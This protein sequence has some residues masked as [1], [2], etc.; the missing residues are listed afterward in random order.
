[1]YT[2]NSEMKASVVERFNR[3]LK[4]KMWR[5]FT[6]KQSL[7][8]IDVLQDLVNSYNSSYHRSIKNS[9][10]KIKKSNEKE[11]YKILF[12]SKTLPLVKFLY[13]KGD[14]VRISKEKGVF[15]KGYTPNF[16]REIF[17]I[18]KVIPR[19]PVVYKL[20][21]LMDEKIE[22]VFYEQQ[23][24]K[25]LKDDDIYYISDLVKTRKKKGKTQY[26]VRW[27][28]YPDKFNSW[29]DAENFVNINLIT[30]VNNTSS[31][32]DNRLTFSF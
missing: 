25:I 11:T 7:R 26:L 19:F 15:S 23:L 6:F 18:D 5:Y 10:N 20:K 8:Y 14:K 28:G 21:D 1:M 9:P 17:I 16:S 4:N 22:G 3:T 29:V 32:L 13:K 2:L 31:D 30:A 27:L 12:E 24:N